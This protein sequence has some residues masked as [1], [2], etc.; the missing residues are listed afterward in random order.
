MTD[1]EMRTAALIETIAGEVYKINRDNKLFAKLTIHNRGIDVKVYKGSLIFKTYSASY[2][3]P[4]LCK[5]LDIIL[6]G[7]LKTRRIAS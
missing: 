2:S 5:R 6:S 3:H 1:N 7:L 4:E